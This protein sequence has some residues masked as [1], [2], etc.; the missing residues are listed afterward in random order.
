[1]DSTETETL[2]KALQQVA[3]QRFL[4]NEARL[5]DGMRL[6]EWLELFTKDCIYWVPCGGDDT[7]PNEDVSIIYDDWQ[8]LAERVWRIN[9]GQA[10]GQLPASKLVHVV[11][12]VCVVEE[13]SDTLVVDST[14]ILAELRRGTQTVYAGRSEYH[15]L[16]Q[17]DSFRISYKRVLLI[18][19]DEPLGNLSFIL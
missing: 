6:S 7:D 18:N 8:R 5:M 19:N 9:T 2:A 11:A 12:N 13:L 14:F 3:V 10:Y 17:D 16:P 1:M 4:F 15:L